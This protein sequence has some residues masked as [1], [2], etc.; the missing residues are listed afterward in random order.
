MTKIKISRLQYFFLIPNLLF[1]KAIGITAG[2][3]AREVGGDAWTAMSIGFLTGVFIMMLMV[4]LVSR[5]DQMTVIQICRQVFGK[6]VGKIVGLI[7]ALFFG[8]AFAASANVM[9]MHLKEYF[10]LE[11][12]FWVICLIYTLLCMYGVF[13]GIETIVRF[14]FF[15]ILGALFINVT[16]LLGTWGDFELINMLPLFDR[17][18]SANITASIYIFGDLALAILGI[19]IIYP[20]LN[21]QTKSV[22]L[23]VWAMVLAGSLIL[24]WPV[25]ELGVMGAGAMQQYVVVCMQQ[26]RCAQLTRYLPRYE[27]IMVAFFTFTTFVQSATMFFCSVYS[28]KQIGWGKKDWHI[29][30]PLALLLTVATY[31]M[32]SDHNDYIAFLAYP[33][34]QLCTILSLGLPALLLLAA[35]VR[36]R[37][38]GSAAPSSL[39]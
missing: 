2:V 31:L 8:L 32:A 10:L 15:G 38:K 19:G 1:S 28:F 16:M 24:I 14:A 12:P 30:L 33:W 37:L 36:G 26:V 9:T 4:Y 21:D 18:V 27:L 5:F 35:L 11:T 13:L 17:G 29:I 20:L 39:K 3:T 34:A 22:S 23:T 7:L 6:W 25:F